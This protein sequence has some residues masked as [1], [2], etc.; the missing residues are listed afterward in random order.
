[1][2]QSD[3]STSAAA[4]LPLV[5]IDP[6]RSKI[7][8]RLNDLWA[9]REL[10]YFLTWRDLKVRY[11]QTV[12][13]AAWAVLQPL[14]TMVLFTLFFGRLAKVPSDGIPY[15]L[16]AF[17]GSL[18]WS[19]TSNAVSNA[20]NSLIADA[21]LVSKVY[22]PRMI[23]PASA[24]AASLVDLLIGLFILFPLMMYYGFTPRLS[25]LAIVPLALLLAVF[26]FAV[27]LWLAGLN[28]IYRDVRYALPFAIQLGMFASPVIYPVT[29]VPERWRWILQ[30]N[31]LSGIIETFRWAVTGRGNLDLQGL[32][33]GTGMTL[34]LLLVA[35]RSFSGVERRFGDLV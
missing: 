18:L 16:F 30:L 22:F 12:L 20:A 27:G 23:V 13:G 8:L 2:T 26:A 9:Y 19:F 32:A 33:I 31:P 14:A 6:S 15:P 11:K 34:V 10:L 25:L 5:V 1:M 3:S 24:V 7:A 35:F 4:V 17:V 28:V 29:I 21:R